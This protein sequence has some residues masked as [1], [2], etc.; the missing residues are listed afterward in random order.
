[1]NDAITRWLFLIHLATTFFMIGLIWFV[2]VVHYPL[3]ARTGIT[4]FPQYERNHTTATTWVVGP[5]M[6][7]EVCSALLLLWFRPTGISILQCVLGLALLGVIW[8]STL[9]F[10]IPC[11]DVLCKGFDATVHKRLVSTNWIRTAAWSL[12]GVLVLTMAW[13]MSL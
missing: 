2:Q 13:S 6:L 7:L 10:Q 1:M 9:V 5:P 11:H 3:F 8:G 12:R 4:E